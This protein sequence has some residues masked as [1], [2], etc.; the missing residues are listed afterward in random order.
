VLRALGEVRVPGSSLLPRYDA[1]LNDAAVDRL[2]MLTA[3][4]RARLPA[5][6]PG[7]N[8]EEY[9]SLLPDN[10]PALRCFPPYSIPAPACSWCVARRASGSAL[11]YASP[12]HRVCRTHRR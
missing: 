6:L 10:R 2:E 8:N 5:A 1:V 3:I 4:P 7:L 12:W 11:V 9:R